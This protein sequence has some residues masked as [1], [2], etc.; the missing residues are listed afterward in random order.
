MLERKLHTLAQDT[1]VRL[2][3]DS[4]QAMLTT[5]NEAGMHRWSMIGQRLSSSVDDYYAP[6]EEISKRQRCKKERSR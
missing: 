3:F 5:M 4:P 1:D 2:S 6:Q